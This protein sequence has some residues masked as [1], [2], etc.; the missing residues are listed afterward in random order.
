MKQTTYWVGK[1]PEASHDSAPSAAAAAEVGTAYAP[2]P[3]PSLR[4]LGGST[5]RFNRPELGT[6]PSARS[7]L[8]PSAADA[9]AAKCVAELVVEQ[10]SALDDSEGEAGG[11]MAGAAAADS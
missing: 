6:S 2:G 8:A 9:A 4:S 7:D 10:D 5:L 1:A 3:C 11:L